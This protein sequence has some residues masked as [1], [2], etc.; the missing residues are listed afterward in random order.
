M[1]AADSALA[2]STVLDDGS[3]FI[4]CDP[5]CFAIIV[6]HLRH[7]TTSVDPAL[8]GRVRGA[9]DSFGVT[10]LVEACDAQLKASA[11]KLSRG[12]KERSVECCSRCG[13]ILADAHEREHMKKLIE[14]FLHRE[15]DAFM[16][17]WWYRMQYGRCRARL[18]HECRTPLRLLRDYWFE[19]GALVVVGVYAA[20]SIPSLFS[21]KRQIQC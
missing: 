19:A 10:S 8:V 4:D 13:E 3:Y 14:Y 1:F 12:A 16:M 9:A 2:P 5:H 6:D 20:T 11:P 7:G 17:A 21:I 15:Q 18:Y